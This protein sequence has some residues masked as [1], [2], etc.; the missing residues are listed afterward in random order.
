MDV[1]VERRFKGGRRSWWD[2]IDRYS[3]GCA[4]E[5]VANKVR[6]TA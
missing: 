4:L 1:G 6:L 3:N 2:D 5:R